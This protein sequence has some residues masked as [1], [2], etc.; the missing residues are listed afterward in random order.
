[1]QALA[2][3]TASEGRLFEAELLRVRGELHLRSDRTA[4]GAARAEQ[5]LC[6][7]LEVARKQ[8]AKSWELRAACS[9]AR[10]W[11]G[12]QKTAAAYEL[13]DE[14]YLWFKEGLS[15][16]ELVSARDLLNRLTR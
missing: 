8:A 9:L 7:A 15:S 2:Q 3:V 6:E 11:Q 10:L 13:L 5:S 16:P 12:Q 4:T 14:T 1:M